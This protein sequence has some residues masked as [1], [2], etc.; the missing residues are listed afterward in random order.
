MKKLILL[1]STAAFIL[2]SCNSS[3]SDEPNTDAST[4]TT[5]QTMPEKEVK[6]ISVTY[7]KVDPGVTTLMKNVLQNYLALKDAL[8]NSNEADAKSSSS[9]IADAVKGFDKSLLTK[10]QKE[11]YDSVSG[12]VLE[13][14]NQIANSQLKDQR[15]HFAV[16]SKD[17]Y[18]LA[19]AYGTGMTLYQE[20]CPMF[21]ATE[22]GAIW[23]SKS[24]DI[25]NPY[26]GEK[27][28]ECGSVDEMIQ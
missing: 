24:K 12:K 13:E 14:A 5:E 23:L 8:T 6:V 20:H 3:N 17:V 26:F 19:K 28:M 9:K 1:C 2:L 16:L 21:N 22:G 10:E 25:R 27:M 4:E 18:E 11:P 7:T 15:K